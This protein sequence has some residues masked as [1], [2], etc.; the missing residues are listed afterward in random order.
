MIDTCDSLGVPIAH[1]KTDGPSTRLPFLGILLD[2]V[3]QTISLPSGKHAEIVAVI[4]AWLH[5]TSCSHTELQSLIGTLSWA[6]KCIPSGRLYIRRMIHLLMAHKAQRGCIPLSRDF[7]LDLRWW[8]TFLPL[9]NGSCSFISPKWTASSVLHLFTDASS[10]LGCGAFYDGRWFNVQWPP[11]LVM[12]KFSIEFLEIIP[13]YLSCLVWKDHFTNARIS[14][15]CDNLGV[16]NAWNK[17]GSSSRA[18][19]HMIRLITSVAA[20]S[21]FTIRIVHIPG[22]LN[23]IA[24]ALSR[25][26]LDRFRLS[27]PFADLQPTPVPPFFDDLYVAGCSQGW[28]SKN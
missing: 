3:A 14:F 21:N 8:E 12:A 28:I 26:Q 7:F 22:A 27:A 11:W 18:I 20:F 2:S 9:W 19:L 15:E 1:D 24:D 13:I 17:L 25:F 6:A 23:T 4:S 5:R 10:T 16:V